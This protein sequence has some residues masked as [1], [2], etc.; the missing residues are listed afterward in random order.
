MAST[1]IYCVK[2]SNGG[3][4]PWFTSKTQLKSYLLNLDYIVNSDFTGHHLFDLNNSFELRVENE[5]DVITA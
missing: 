4:S 5:L 3:F 1:K 2:F